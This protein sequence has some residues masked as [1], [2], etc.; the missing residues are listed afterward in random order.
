[1]DHR[2]LSITSF[3]LAGGES[4]RMGQP[5]AL[6]VLAGETMLTRQIRLLQ[7]VAGRVAVVGFRPEYSA[8]FT[9]PLFPDEIT[10]RGPLAGIYTGLRRTATEYN[11][12]LGCDLPFVDRRL[13]HFLAKRALESKAGA[14]VPLSSD[15]RLQPLCAIYSRRARYAIRATLAE[16]ENKIMRFFSKVRCDIIAW[17][18]LARA[19]FTP[20]IFANMNTPEDYEAAQGRLGH[21]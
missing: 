15:G 3:V 8:D 16:G 10:G 2:T 9:V 6:L 21:S 18:D 12:F 19:G 5:K 1:M 13:L 4:R 14:T 11:L 17:Q 20:S 7:S